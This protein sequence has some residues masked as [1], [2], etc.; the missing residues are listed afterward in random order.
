MRGSRF[1]RLATALVLTLAI[2]TPA[3][4][5]DAEALRKELEQMRKQLQETQQQYQKSIDAPSD[6]LRRLEAQPQPVATPP[7]V[8]PAVAMQAPTTPPPPTS[9]SPSVMDLL[10]RREP[11]ALYGTRGPGQFLFD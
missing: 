10:R 6:R 1:L 3:M 5:Q 11:F 9:S 4:A 7:A 2:T 8:P